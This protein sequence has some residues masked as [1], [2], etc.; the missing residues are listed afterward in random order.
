MKTPQKKTNFSAPIPADLKDRIDRILS[1]ADIPIGKVVRRLAEF[2]AQMSPEQVRMFVYGPGEETL[3]S[4][5]HRHVAEYL[6]SEDGRARLE[7]LVTDFVA[8]CAA[9]SSR[10]DT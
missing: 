2:L 8:V 9:R 3:E 10:A 5:I 7:A 4:Y 1:D 6:D